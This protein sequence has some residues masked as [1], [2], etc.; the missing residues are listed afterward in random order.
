MSFK[1]TVYEVTESIHCPL[2]V[3]GD[4]MSLT[5]RSCSCGTGK[6]VCLVLARDFMSLLIKMQTDPAWQQPE[7]CRDLQLQRLHRPDQVYRVL[8]E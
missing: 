2:Y 6:E 5:M 4:T 7:E 3:E 8:P 1:K